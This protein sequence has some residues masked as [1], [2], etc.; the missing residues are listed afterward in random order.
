MEFRNATKEEMKS[1]H[2]YIDRMSQTLLSVPIPDNATNGDVIKAMF[3]YINDKPNRVQDN[4]NRIVIY[5]DMG[6]GWR[7]IEFEKDWLNAPYNYNKEVGEW[8]D[9]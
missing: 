7:T 9:W 5:I 4:G 2:D 1:T 3:P 8:V 6:F